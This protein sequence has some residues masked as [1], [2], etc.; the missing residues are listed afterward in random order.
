M[1]L[2]FNHSTGSRAENPEGSGDIGRQT[3]AVPIQ[4]ASARP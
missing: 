1:E 2:P 3:S 4:G